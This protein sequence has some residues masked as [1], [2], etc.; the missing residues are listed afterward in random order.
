MLSRII[1]AAVLVIALTTVPASGATLTVDRNRAQRP[2]AQAAVDGARAGDTV[3]VCAGTYSEQVVVSR[4]LKLKGEDAVVDPPDGSFT[5]RS[6]SP[7]TT[8]SCAAS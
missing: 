5:V 7:P 4:P 1:C 3:K 2:G 6:G 8:S